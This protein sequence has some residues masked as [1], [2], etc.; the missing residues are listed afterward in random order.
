MVAKCKISSEILSV[1]RVHRRAPAVKYPYTASSEG[2][3]ILSC[4]QL[5]QQLGADKE[6]YISDHSQTLT[7]LIFL[8]QLYLGYVFGHV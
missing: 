4:Q 7:R 8:H 6:I 2:L 5:H 3:W 1:D